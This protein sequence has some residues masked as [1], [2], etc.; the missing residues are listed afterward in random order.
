LLLKVMLPGCILNWPH[1]NFGQRGKEE[2]LVAWNHR[3]RGGDCL[4]FSH[5]SRCILLQPYLF[6]SPYQ[7]ALHRTLLFQPNISFS[8][9]LHLTN[10]TSA[11]KVL[12]T[13][14]TPPLHHTTNHHPLRHSWTSSQTPLSPSTMRPANHFPPHH[15]STKWP[16]SL[17]NWA[18]KI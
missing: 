12:A 4:G 8:Y 9:R 17:V 3:W 10:T 14:S 15:L 11:E 1:L 18:L 5:G 16:K 13:P 2:W 6:S 7:H